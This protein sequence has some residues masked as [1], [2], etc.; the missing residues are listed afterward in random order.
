MNTIMNHDELFGGLVRLARQA[1]EAI[2][3][4]YE[5]GFGV[6]IKSDGSPLTMA[7]SASHHILLSGL[8]S[9]TPD[10]PI[11]SEETVS[12]DIDYEQRKEWQRFW[13]VDPLDGTKEFIKRNGEFT[14]N[15]A[16]VENGYPVAGLI[17]VPVRDLYYFGCSGYGAWKMKGVEGRPEKISVRKMNPDEQLTVVK[18]RSH[19]SAELDDFLRTIRVGS[20]VSAGSALKFCLVAEGVADLYP[21]FGP[22]MEWDTAAGQAIVEAAG[23]SVCDPQGNRFRYN[24]ESLRNGYFIVRGWGA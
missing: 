4:I 15:I 3:R 13:L 22:T 19:P 17:Y 1:G 2:L 6:E 21:R 7:D 9:L 18:S 23:G 24:K 11:I 10:V 12:G 16:L 5:T 8:P 14:V 20:E